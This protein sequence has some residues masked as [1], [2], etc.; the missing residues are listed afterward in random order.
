MSA[1]D[2]LSVVGGNN[3]I[4]QGLADKSAA[5]LHLNAGVKSLKKLSGADGHTTWEVTT[6]TGDMVD[7]FDVVVVAAPWH[8]TGIEVIDS[9]ADQ[10][11]GPAVEYVDLHVTLV[12]TNATSPQDC[13]FLANSTCEERTQSSV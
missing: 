13:F 5:Q 3:Q 11:A 2:T 1:T 7:T 10:V 9:V 12:V 6:L 8:Q 4:F